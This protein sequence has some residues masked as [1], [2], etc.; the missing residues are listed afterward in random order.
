M[1][2][3]ATD[4]LRH[5]RNALTG[6]ADQ[7]RAAL[8]LPHG[9]ANKVADLAR[10]LGRAARQRAHLGRH[11]GKTPAL[12]ARACR[13]HGGIQ[14]QDVGLEGDA[15][16]HLDDLAHAT[17]IVLDALHRLHR[18]RHR[19][20]A[21]L[22]GLAHLAGALIGHA[23][24]LRVVV[25]GGR[26]L[27]HAGRGLLQAG[28]LLL[29]AVGQF[30]VVRRQALTRV[31]HQRRV[32]ANVGHHRRERVH[33]AVEL[34]AHVR[35]FIAA[36][37]FGPAAQ[38]ALRRALHYAA[39]PPQVARHTGLESRGQ[40]GG[41]QHRHATHGPRGARPPP[42]HPR[43]GQQCQHGHASQQGQLGRETQAPHEPYARSQNE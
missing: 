23:S 1:P 25:H 42:L 18:P 13:F 3:H 10:R 29:G 22:S 36:A 20:G 39:Q 33:H 8:H 43:H 28:G 4:A 30:A 37:H 12:L 27:L 19:L 16:D 6:G 15:V 32:A 34:L 17:G 14:R 9:R 35:Q 38:V 2:G 40:I 7:P 24:R 5:G 26:Q 31:R 41:G 21:R 11:H